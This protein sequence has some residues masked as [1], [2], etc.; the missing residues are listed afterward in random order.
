M[1]FP[2]RREYKNISTFVSY[3]TVRAMTRNYTPDERMTTWLGS[4]IRSDAMT[5]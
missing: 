5:D 3:A 4:L 1:V 2:E